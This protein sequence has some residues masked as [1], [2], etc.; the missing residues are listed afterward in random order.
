MAIHDEIRSAIDR[1]KDKASGLGRQVHAHPEQ[2][3]EEHFAAG[4]LADALGELGL[5]VKRGVGG[6]ETAFRA[7]TGRSDKSDKSDESGPTIAILAEYDAL[8][9]GHSCGHNLICT[10]ALSAFAGLAAIRDQL[11]GRIVILGTPAEEGGGGKI[12]MMEKGALKGVD[13]AMMVHPMDGEFATFPALATR[14]LRIAFHGRAAHASAAPWAGVSALSAVIQTFQSVDA[15]RLH[16]RDGSRIHG[17]IT[18]GGQ[19]V[20][21]IPEK[22]ECEFLC[23]AYTTKYAR[24]IADRVLRCAEG[25][26]TA[27]GTTLTHEVGAGY[28]NMINNLAMA[29]RYSRHCEALGVKAPDAPPDMPTGSTDMGDV[30]HAVPAIH[31]VFRIADPGAGNCHEERFEKHTDTPRAY[32]AM[33]RVAKAMALTAYDLLADTALMD[34]ARG[35]FARRQ[36]N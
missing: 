16:F 27:T 3:F 14:H 7:E 30:S 15:A 5:E 1:F 22:T 18:N 10:A 21:I 6:L 31:P 33:I 36:E 12:I 19:A 20:N 26:A 2:K 13:A 34:S 32:E 4:L 23:R 17:I 9:N 8:P 25:A 24:E 11:P 28:K 29:H 35:E